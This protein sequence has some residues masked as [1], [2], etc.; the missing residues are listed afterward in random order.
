MI[1]KSTDNVKNIIILINHIVLFIDK[2]NLK[3]YGEI[4]FSYLKGFGQMA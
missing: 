1:E 4:D 2:R 3:N